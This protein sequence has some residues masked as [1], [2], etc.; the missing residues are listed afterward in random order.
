M[1][2]FLRDNLHFARA[3]AR[4]IGAGFL[5]TFFSSFG[6]T[7]FIGLSGNDIRTRFGLSGGEFGGLYMAATL[8]SA[9]TLPWLGRS[10]DLAPGWKVA[11]F[12]VPLLAAACLLLA[13][14]PHVLVLVL[15]LYLLRLFGQGMMTE[16][17]FTETG[18]W[19]VSSRGRAMALVVMG[20]QAGSALLPVAFVLARDAGDWRTPWVVA[21]A[22]LM[23]A[24][25]P[26]ILK[27]MHEPRIP[28][29]REHAQVE[30]HLARDWTRSEVIRDP[31]FYLLL[32]GVLAPPFIGTTIFF[33]Q[34]YLI[35]LRGYD[36]LVFVG[37]FPV[38]AVTTVVF[39]LVCGHLV[40]R[41]GALRLLPFFLAP[42]AV[43]CLVVGLVTPVWGV[44]VF[45][46]LLGISSGFTQTLLGA[47]WP[48]VYGL[49][50][51]GGI[52]AI[53]VAAMVL[54]TALGPGLTGAIIDMGVAL[55]AQ[56]IWM[57]AWCV[58]ASAVLGVAARM[59]RARRTRIGTAHGG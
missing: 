35:A 44:Y 3:N 9:L 37:A 14:A 26:V 21:A 5:L 13:F 20:L 29:A 2:L 42:L 58:L 38:M 1:R 48:E 17:A 27:L 49:A 7:F 43:A 16:I 10:L 18:R 45:M 30:Q 23:V 51:L 12:S 46:F 47:L 6:Q 8:A 15:A 40:D 22:L 25:Y 28:H 24:G 57:A 19:F 59:I 33:H 41:Y 56:M 39:G 36:P 50:N 4:W 55:P 11:R 52:R 34:G 54:S 32:V 31:A 53:I